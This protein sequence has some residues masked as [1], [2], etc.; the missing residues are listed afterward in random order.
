MA[1]TSEQLQELASKMDQAWQKVQVCKRPTHQVRNCQADL[2]AETYAMR[3]Y[4]SAKEIYLRAVREAR[5]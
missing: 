2:D 4:Q 5:L 3:E 1:K